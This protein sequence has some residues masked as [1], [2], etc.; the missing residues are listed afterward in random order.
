GQRAGARGDHA[1][2][3]A[4]GRLDL[5]AARV[6]AAGPRPALA[7][8][9]GPRRGGRGPAARADLGRPAPLD[10][11]AL[12]GPLVGVGGAAGPP[13]RGARGGGHRPR[14][15]GGA[16]S[17]RAGAG[18]SRAGSAAAWG[19]PVPAAPARRGR[20]G[21]AGRRALQPL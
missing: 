21:P 11:R 9:G 19:A 13:A 7:A 20:P 15:G 10:R 12:R 8:R 17:R 5:L 6:G 18:R 14:A 1:R 4:V 2:P 16:G 3:D